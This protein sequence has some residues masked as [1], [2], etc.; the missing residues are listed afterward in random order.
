M[1]KVDLRAVLQEIDRFHEL[2]GYAPTVRD[3][4][5]GLG[6]S[7]TSITQNRFMKLRHMG[8]IDWVDGIARTLTITQEGIKYMGGNN[9]D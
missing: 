5:H 3:I 4:Q 6:L 7:S 9:N 8:Y 1:S 2:N